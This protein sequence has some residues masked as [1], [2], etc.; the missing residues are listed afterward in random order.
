M[1]FIL[2]IAI[3]ACSSKLEVKE[4]P[5]SANSKQEMLNLEAAIE[6]AKSDEY[7]LLS[8]IS[9]Q[10]AQKSLEKSKILE[11]NNE[12]NEIV[13]NKIAIGQAYVS[14][15]KT[16]GEKVKSNM[17]D[18]LAARQ[19]AITAKAKIY[20]PQDLFK[21][22]EKLKKETYDIEIDKSSKLKEKRSEFI[23]AYIDLELAAIKHE[24]IGASQIIIEDSIKNGA[25]EMTP[26]T[27]GE[28]NKKYNEA[29]L[30]ITKNRHN[31]AG[32]QN[33]SADLF[34][35]AKNLELTL[36]NTRGITSSTPEVAALKIQ[37]EEERLDMGQIA[38]AKNQQTINSL[39]TSNEA[40]S[41][42]QKL[43]AI[44]ENAR[45]KFNP[46]E[47]EV[48][49]QGNNLVIRLRALEFAPAQSVIKSD[50]FGLLKKVED[51][52]ESFE[53]SRVTVE[54]HTDS[55]GDKKFNQK[56]SYF[57]AEAVKQYLEV[58]S[59][60]K[61]STIEIKGFGDDKPLAS[62]KTSLGRA[63]NRR[64]DVIIG[65]DQL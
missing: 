56:L 59:S 54:G 21:L 60:D 17:P 15:A 6:S 26:K 55:I 20:L 37:A 23:T 29:D 53:N 27:L 13:L 52:I 43:S 18:I 51:V 5:K 48:Y 47:A 16:R 36:V 33:R 64:V 1:P 39:K 61:I 8:P 41:R 38:L 40:F 12:K 2:A 35:S 4:F 3:S 34:K 50:K 28:T 24:H 57:R 31:I 22:D 49:K 25:Y 58:N 65:P 30:Y 14:Q 63:Q 11:R 10:E 46:N 19:L 32:I 62:N 45:G 42:Q 7:D 9:F 44:Y